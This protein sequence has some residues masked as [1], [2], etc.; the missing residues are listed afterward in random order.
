MSKVLENLK[1]LKSHEWIRMEGKVGVIGIT[2][3]A[4]DSLGAIVYVELG[5]VGTEIKQ[6]SEFGAVESVKA[7][8]DIFAPVSGK[9]IE[10]NQEVVDSPELI[11]EDA[12]QNWLIKVEIE[13]EKELDNLLD[14]AAYRDT[15]Q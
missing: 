8:S 13:D 6:F 14:A 5:D 4:Q 15:I 9:I 3:Y 7:A 10:V 12:Y 2:D 11:N 1:Y